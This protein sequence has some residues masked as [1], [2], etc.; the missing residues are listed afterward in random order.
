MNL[1]VKAQMQAE[2][3]FQ[4]LVDA[5]LHLAFFLSHVARHPAPAIIVRSDVDMI[6]VSTRYKE[7]NDRKNNSFASIL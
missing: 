1:K 4:H 2:Q 7:R 3:D 6:R 5:N